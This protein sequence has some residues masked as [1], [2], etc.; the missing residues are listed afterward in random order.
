MTEVGLVNRYQSSNYH[1]FTCT[2]TSNHCVDGGRWMEEN[3]TPLIQVKH[4]NLSNLS[5]I[6]FPSMKISAV[7]SNNT[8]DISVQKINFSQKLV[9]TNMRLAS[10]MLAFDSTFRYAVYDL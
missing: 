6:L 9:S 10:Y 8:R 4:S 5:Q 3:A 7:K 2:P 1:R